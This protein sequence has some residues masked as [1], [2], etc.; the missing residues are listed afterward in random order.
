MSRPLSAFVAE[1][2]GLS[3]YD[4]SVLVSDKAV[5]DYY[6][7]LAEGRDAKAAANW[8]INELFGRLKKDDKGITESPVTPAQL[9]SI[10][11]ESV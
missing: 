1:K 11:K 7:K 6:E 8:V 10:V 3:V 5:S 4:A 9:G 2:L